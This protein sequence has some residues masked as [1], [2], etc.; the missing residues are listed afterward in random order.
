[1]NIRRLQKEL[2]MALRLFIK[3]S[4]RKSPFQPSLYIN[5]FRIFHYRTSWPQWPIQLLAGH[6]C[7]WTL[8]EFPP[9]M[10]QIWNEWPMFAK[11]PPASVPKPKFFDRVMH[12][13]NSP[14]LELRCPWTGLELSLHCSWCFKL[15]LAFHRFY[16]TLSIQNAILLMYAKTWWFG[17]GLVQL[18]HHKDY[19]IYFQTC[20]SI[21][22][23]I[24]KHTRPCRPSLV[25]LPI[26]ADLMGDNWL[27]EIN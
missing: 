22:F 25:T 9:L 27:C 7:C 11:K 5:H 4:R 20:G 21:T 14:R 13:A 10:L 15:A 8:L 3:S 19:R 2:S 18:W 26:Q 1:M 12:S 6:L 23:D 17:Q 16:T 24:Q